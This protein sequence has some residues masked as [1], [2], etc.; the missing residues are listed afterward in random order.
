MNTQN[1]ILILIIVIISFLL[2][3]FLN[4]QTK[5]QFNNYKEKI[6]IDTVYSEKP[7]KPIIIEKI[8][9]K[10]IYRRDTIIQTLPFSAKIDTI[11]FRDTIKINYQFPENILDF[12]IYPKPDSIEFRNIYITK[13]NEKK[14][15]WWHTSAGILSGIF[16]GYLI[17]SSK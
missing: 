4:H 9:P 5:N 3:Y 11:I 7:A 13:A 16:L 10:L 12:A 8:K 17:G 15:D 14:N 1:F 6:L 2:G